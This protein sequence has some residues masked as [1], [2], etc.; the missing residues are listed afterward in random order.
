M[1]IEQR[2]NQD[3]CMSK[4]AQTEV[5]N[6]VSR[7]WVLCANDLETSISNVSNAEG[8]AI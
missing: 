8:L 7:G 5:L 6:G 3:N 2:N 4:S 1:S